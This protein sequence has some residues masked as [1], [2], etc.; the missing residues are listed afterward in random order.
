ME[1][2]CTILLESFSYAAMQ[3]KNM[4]QRNAKDIVKNNNN[5]RKSKQRRRCRQRKR[6]LGLICEI[7]NNGPF[8]F[9]K[10][11]RLRFV[12]EY[13]CGVNSSRK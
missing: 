11:Q 1:L 4:Q 5:K 6:C 3:Q 13:Y 10:G 7:V 9:N 12:I 2:I 8:R